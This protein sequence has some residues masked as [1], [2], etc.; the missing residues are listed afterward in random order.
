MSEFNISAKVNPLSDQS[1]RVKAMASVTI[2]NAIT[3]SDM[4]IVEGSNGLFIGYPQNKDKDGNY[5][6]IVEFIKDE[7][8]KMTAQSIGLKSKIHKTLIDL[9]KNG[10]RTTPEQESKEPVMHD[11]RAFVTPLRDSQSATKGL[12]TIQ[13]GEL[14]KV[15]S[16]RVNENKTTKENFVA[17]PSRPDKTSNSGYRRMVRPAN[18][19]FGEKLNATI[20]KR[21]DI[22]LERQNKT[23][24]KAQDKPQ[25]EQ[26]KPA[27]NKAAP[28]IE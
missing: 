28:N 20:L 24:D 9:Y 26:D 2:D 23:N 6:D 11:I 12:A 4:T 22:R 18:E 3:I 25:S 16:I 14:F 19:K 21:Y 7:Q 17:L 5:R 13:V 10:E 27:A 1:G 8:G 15:N